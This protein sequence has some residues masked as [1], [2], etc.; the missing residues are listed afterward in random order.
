[1]KTADL[2]Y[3]LDTELTRLERELAQSVL[4]N[5]TKL[6]ED[7]LQFLNGDAKRVRPILMFL[8]LKTLGLEISDEHYKIAVATELLHAAS[9]IHDDIIDNAQTRRAQTAWHKRFGGKL[10]TVAGDY[11]FALSLKV[12][13][14]LQDSKIF[15]LFTDSALNI[16][17]GEISQHFKRFEVPETEEYLEKSRLKTGVLFWC[18]VCAALHV[19]GVKNPAAEEFALSFGTAFQIKNDLNSERDAKDGIYTLPAIYFKQENPDC[20]IIRPSAE[21]FKKAQEF[22]DDFVAQMLEKLEGMGQTA[23]TEPLERFCKFLK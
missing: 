14:E 1:M 6:D 11:L 20:D 22:L 3:S 9:L 16:C 8:I 2:Q 19:S 7:F 4:Q 23:Q 5:N 17:S 12:I 13:S 21:H 18:A 15:K 10:A